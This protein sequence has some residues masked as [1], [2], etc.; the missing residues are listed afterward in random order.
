MKKNQL[1][2]TPP[3]KAYESKHTFKISSASWIVGVFVFILLFI[4]SRYNYLIFHTIAELIS[5][6]VAWSV[7][8]LVW[9]ARSYIQNSA[10]IYLGIFYF[11]V[12]GIDLIHTISYKGMGILESSFN[13]N[14]A[15][16]LWIAA[17]YL[18]SMSLCIF[19]FLFYR[20]ISFIPIFFVYSIIVILSLLSIFT[21]NI[22]PICY[23]EG[24]GLTPFKK[25]S[26][27]V[28]CMILLSA[29]LAIRQRRH[30]L[31]SDVYHLMG[32]SIFLTILEELAFTFYVSVYGLSN[33]AGHFLK[34]ISFFCI[35]KSIIV[36]GIKRP[37]ELLFRN[38]QQREKEYKSTLNNLQIGVIVHAPDTNIIFSNP[39]ASEI[40]GM[41]FEQMTG[42]KADDSAWSFLYEDETRMKIQ[43]Y[44]INKV[45]STR[46]SLKNY[47]LG[48]RR[49]DRD[50]ITWVAANAI[51][52]FNDDNAIEKGIVNF[53]DITDLKNAENAK[54]EFLSN[55]S[56]EIR[57]PIN[58]IHMFSKILIDQHIGGLNKKQYEY[59]NNII[60]S[61][62]R[63]IFQINDILDLSK[64]ASGKVEITPVAFCVNHLMERL[65]KILVSLAS[66]KNLSTQINVSSDVPSYLVG[67]ELRIEQILRNLISNAIK[68]TDEGTVVVSLEKQSSGGYLFKVTDT[69][70]GIP[71]HQQKELF[72]KFFQADSS[73]AKKYAGSGLGLAISKEM[74]ELMDG[75]IGFESQVGKGSTFYFT[76]KLNLPDDQPGHEPDHQKT[77]VNPMKRLKKSLKILLAEDDEFNRQAI[78]YFLEREGHKI[79]PARNGKE[80]IDYLETDPFDIILMD[81]QMPEMD[82]IAATRQIRRS[83]NT[84]FDPN[85]PVIALTAYAMKGDQE[86]YIKAGLNDYVSKPIDYKLLFEKMYVLIDQ[87]P[88]HT[89]CQKTVADTKAPPSFVTDIQFF[90][91]STKGDPDFLKDSLKFFPQLVAERLKRLETSILTKDTK[92]IAV[93]SHKF[94]A[95]FSAIYIRE[96]SQYSHDLQNA[97]RAGN[98]E[99]CEIIFQDLKAMMDDILNYINAME[100]N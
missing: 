93:A 48:I 3:A 18:E 58:A 70:I 87:K 31:D 41:S 43:D 91:E 42:K 78:T 44:P 95:L 67:D 65:R 51:P 15:T 5:I 29:F 99:K 7:F 98:L 53:A 4:T 75:E 94:I 34:I 10:L 12:G 81:I 90:I 83:K 46:T 28:I 2:N 24:V 85:I 6:I 77:V 59:V 47:V 22:F 33:L 16:Q 79:T 69:G 86:K 76:L 64:L 14:P 36:T 61:S 49:S 9:N 32:I 40:M 26:E 73:Y 92:E 39:K 54:S 38:L 57:T 20:R 80:T 23:V 30:A 11:F 27:Y 45:F 74:V 56:H 66:D 71:K 72:D 35:Y 88:S 19:P 52:I 55:M 62:N 82:G 68:F 17:R 100:V 97:A 37:H 21:W 13:A 89:K 96:A 1:N 84:T 25:I 8:L 60:E 50:Y 63:L